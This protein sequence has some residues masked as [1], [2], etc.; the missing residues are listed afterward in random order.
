MTD[1]TTEFFQEL[2]ARGHEPQLENVT[3]TMRF[4]LKNGKRTARWVVSIT[5]GDIAVSH[6]NVKADCVVRADRTVFEGIASGEVNAF[7]AVLRGLMGVEGSTD[8]L[9][10]F[11]RL[12][13]APA[14]KN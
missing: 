10:R 8:L 11:Q 2:D 5:K 4:D 6:K 13:P 1:A 7:A 12:F 3:A 9:V 14:R